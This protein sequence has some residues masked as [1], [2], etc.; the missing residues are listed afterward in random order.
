M[1]RS[2]VELPIEVNKLSRALYEMY[3][4]NKKVSF[5]TTAYIEYCADSL[6]SNLINGGLRNF[7]KQLGGVFNNKGDVQSQLLLAQFIKDALWQ[8]DLGVFMS[9]IR[10][11]S[12]RI[13]S[14]TKKTA[15][16]A[17]LQ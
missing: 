14:P 3:C 17:E 9:R 4:A 1:S 2:S 6:K 8:F 13:I 16:I 11:V 5:G 12:K 15:I 10:T 7:L